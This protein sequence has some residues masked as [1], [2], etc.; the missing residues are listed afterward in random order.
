MVGEKRFRFLGVF[1]LLAIVLIVG[2]V[3]AYITATS[4]T[5]ADASGASADNDGNFTINWTNDTI[6][7]S[8][9]GNWTVTVW[10]NESLFNVTDNAN[11]T[12]TNLS[13]G[14]TWSNTTQGNYTFAFSAFFDNGTRG[15]NS[16]NV[17]MY[18][19]STVPVVDWADSGYTNATAKKNTTLLTLNIS[20]ADTLSGFTDGYCVFDINE[21]NET[22][23]V[24]GDWCNTTQL[25]LTGLDDGNH[26]IDIWV[27][28]SANNVGVSLSTYVVWVDTTAPVAT[29]TCDP[30][31]IG[32]L[33]NT[34]CTCTG[35][36]AG[37]GVN[38]SL[39]TAAVTITA[40]ST[41]GTFTTG[42]SNCTITDYAG[43]THTATGTYTVASDS[44]TDGTSSSSTTALKWT[45]SYSISDN[46]FN[47]GYTQQLATKGRIKFKVGSTIHQAGVLEL[48]ETTAKIEVSSTPQ[49]ATLAIGD[50]RKFD[51]SE[52]GYYDLVVMLNSILDSKA[53]L[54]IKSI[55][56]LITTES[57]AGEQEKEESAGVAEGGEEIQE[58]SSIFKKW[59]FW[60]IVALVIV[61][62]GYYVKENNSK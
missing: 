54:T 36:D 23:A 44:A 49:E 12:G 41:Y 39:T 35:T 11:T 8:P 40:N 28:D 26:T 21:T 59:W 17:S 3:W 58:S 47:E 5:F 56:E 61:G 9:I 38:S 2:F 16:T 34:V 18:V 1:F 24:S 25:N 29:F 60:L 7:V 4:I 6:P 33:A 57:E 31:T 55:N 53:D 45:R 42:T 37:V 62:I 48:T 22:V 10:V 52:D 14:Y 30:S 15:T 20:V 46:Q 13:W 51:V 27:N 19:D 43:N 50:T 32:D